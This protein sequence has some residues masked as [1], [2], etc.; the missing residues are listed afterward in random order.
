MPQRVHELIV[1][2]TELALRRFQQQEA[3]KSGFVDASGH[4]TFSRLRKICLPY[5]SIK[6]TPM[7]AVQQLLLQRQVVEV[8]FGHFTGQ[9]A[10]G[11]LS[12]NA[13]A[14]VLEKLITELASLPADAQE[15]INWLL[16]Q[17]KGSRLYQLGTLASIWRAT[18]QQEGVV[19][20]IGVNGAI[21]KL[22]RGNRNKWPPILRD[23]SRLT[24]RSVR[25][26]NPFEEQCVSALNQKLKISVES[27]LPHAHAEAAADRLGQKIQAE[28]MAEPWAMWTEDLGDALAVNSPEILSLSD[29]SRISFSRSAG[30]YGE[31]EDLARRIC[32]NLQTLHIPANRIALVVPNIGQVQ[33]VVP[34]VF[35]R[36]QIPYFFRR[37]RPVLSSA[38]VKSFMAWLAF[39]LRPERNIMLDLVRNPVLA[40]DDREAETE[41]LLREPPRLRMPVKDMSGLQALQQLNAK[42]IEPEDHFNREA[43]QRL[44][45]V[46]ECIGSQ[47]LPLDELV[48]L[49]EKLL[50]NETVKPRDS[51]EQGVWIIN[52]H[53]A[54]G[55]D[56][57]VVLFAGL[58]EGE[59]PAVPQQ[60]A[61]LNDRERFML[62][63]H[64]EQQGRHLPKMALPKADVLF[65]QQSVLFLT[66]LGMARE[67]LV[68]SYQAVDQEGNEKGEGE[69]FRKLWNLAGWPAQEEMRLSPYD[70]CR[71]IVLAEDNF[72]S[73]H[74]QSQQLTTPEDRL[75][76][77]GESF[78]PIIPLPLCRA[79]DEALQSAV[80]GGRSADGIE[81]ATPVSGRLEHLVQ[82]LQME[83]ERE[84]YLETAIEDRKPSVYCG[85]IEALKDQVNRWL[86]KKQEL[87]ATALEALAQNRYIFLLERVFGIYDPRVADDTPDPM[88]RGGLIHS[89]LYEIY[90][91]VANGTSGIDA[92]RLFAVKTSRGWSR[93]SE[94]G[95]DAVPLAAFDPE[96]CADYEAFALDVANRMMDEEQLG[97]PGIWAAER[98][99]ILEMVLNFVRYDVETCA[100]ENRYPALFELKF[101]GETAVDLSCTKVHGAIDR[102]DLIFEETGELQKVR[103]LDYKGSS[104][105]RTKRD[106][107]IAEIIRNLDCQLPVYALAAQQQF[108][109]EVNTADANARTEAGYLI[110]ERDFSRLGKQFQKSLIPMDE[111]GML[112]GFFRTLERNIGKLKAGDFAVDP[113][114]AAY[115]DY[116]SICRTEA[117]DWED[118]AYF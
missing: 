88:E 104:K 16:G 19:D 57:D 14:E 97:H 112:P 106:E 26:F 90:S 10:L 33:D 7:E 95:V 53:D 75:P 45:D 71:L 83:A 72:I 29:V 27:A 69:Y 6:G 21:L 81:R 24:F 64:L 25:W 42:V 44:K 31:I 13:L 110:C 3:L 67:Q 54:V 9:G 22:L 58:N 66:A 87:S 84:E 8:A 48:D 52:P 4:T 68:F 38:V 100:A 108:F 5:A 105:A 30:T 18:L 51:H 41:R 80:Q 62:R 99:K 116:T 12:A 60:D 77:P 115:N 76:M 117:V 63:T 103:V 73:D 85:H 17:R 20:A 101:G 107:Y 2:P 111:E 93:R 56:F 34:N 70:Q 94:G 50:E 47:A 118:I 96:R 102:I 114:I 1:F 46:L 11:K 109:G 35:S 36:F 98:R 113:L 59:F 65:E 74:W 92:P 91:A 79:E 37:G 28:I 40:F 82:M 61:L 55:L 78:L 86:E 32:W 15:I 23:C 43:L 49:V 89:I 39:P